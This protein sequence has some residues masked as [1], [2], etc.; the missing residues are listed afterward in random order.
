MGGSGWEYRVPFVGSVAG[1]LVATQEQVL[2]SGDYIWPWEYDDAGHVDVDVD[3]GED[4][5]DDDVA[6]RPRSLA[7]LGRAKQVEEFWDE[8]THSILDVERVWS[9]ED[10]D[11]FGLVRPLTTDEA[12]QVLG[13]ETP[14]ALDFDRVHQPGPSGPLADLTGPR[15]SGRSVVIYAAGAPVE[16]YF[17]GV[18]GD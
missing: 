17:W 7:A 18:S 9:E 16:V 8:G 15:W 1:S 6:T 2:S 13:A 3:V 5:D 11:V 14:S 10:E 12:E 4:D